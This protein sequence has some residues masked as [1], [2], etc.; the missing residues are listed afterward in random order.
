[1]KEFK[2]LGI[3][4]P[5]KDAEW[6]LPTSSDFYNFKDMYV[7]TRLCSVRMCLNHSKEGRSYNE[8][9]SE[10]DYFSWLTEPSLISFKMTLECSPIFYELKVMN[11]YN[12]Q[13]L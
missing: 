11:L 3:Y 9:N 2:K 5:Q 7:I 4:V 10:W 6:E 13:W 8:A 1:M 12:V